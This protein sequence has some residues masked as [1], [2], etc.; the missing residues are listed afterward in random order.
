MI[1]ML[2]LAGDSRD[3]GSLLVGGTTPTDEEL[4]DFAKCKPAAVRSAVAK[5]VAMDTLV[6]LDDGSLRF[7]NWDDFQRAPKPSDSAE[8]TRERKAR[9]RDKKRAGH[10]DVT[11][12][13]TPPVTPPSRGPLKREEKGIEIP[14]VRPRG[15]L[16]NGTSI[17]GRVISRWPW[18]NTCLASSR[19]WSRWL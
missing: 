13:M 1:G 16:G 7:V 15:G 5:L 12:D 18:Q 9:E 11:R 4:A 19:R 6:R 2:C 10:A 3:R 8:A 17:S 14:P